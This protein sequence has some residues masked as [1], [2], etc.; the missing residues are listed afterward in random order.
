MFFIWGV[1]VSLTIRIQTN[2]LVTWTNVAI[3]CAFNRN[4]TIS[5]ARFMNCT[6][7]LY[8]RNVQ[9]L[10]AWASID[11]VLM[12][13]TTGTISP[14]HRVIHEAHFTLR[15]KIFIINLWYIIN[16]ILSFFF[17]FF[18]S[19]KLSQRT[20][21]F[22]LGTLWWLAWIIPTLS[23]APIIILNCS[24]RSFIHIIRWR[25]LCLG[26]IIMF[27]TSYIKPFDIVVVFI[28]IIS[29]PS[30]TLISYFALDFLQ[31]FLA[32]TILQLLIT[33]TFLQ[34]FFALTF[35]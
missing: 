13:L 5:L 35:M 7:L 26:F 32:L 9:L 27:S 33:L 21:L 3:F 29:R 11:I 10:L 31:L 4:G 20:K 14:H 19:S 30:W 6:K 12:R 22:Q 34:L 8:R 18:H 2:F 17:F 15:L 24:D 25:K 1:Y 16:N 28:V 23:G